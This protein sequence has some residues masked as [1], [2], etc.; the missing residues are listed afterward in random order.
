MR[1]FT[2]GEITRAKA[3]RNAY[4]LRVEIMDVDGAWVNLSALLGTDWVVS[5]EW[6]GALDQPAVSGR[7]EI[8]REG[9]PAA[10]T[11]PLMGASLVNRDALDEYAPLLRGNARI[12]WYTS[13]TLPGE[14]PAWRE[15]FTGYIDNVDFARNPVTL[16]VRDLTARILDAF[17]RSEEIYAASDT[18]VE[19]VIQAIFDNNGLLDVTVVGGV[20]PP[21]LITEYIQQREK[22][23]DAV[24][25]LL[26]PTGH[27][28]R[29]RYTAADAYQFTVLKPIPDSPVSLYTLGGTDYREVQELKIDTASVRNVVQVSWVDEAGVEHITDPITDAASIAKHGERYVLVPAGPAIHTEAEAIAL[30][31]MVLAD[32]KDELST[33]IYEAYYLP[34]TELNDTLTLEANG[35]HYDSDQIVHVYGWAHR[36][37]SDGTAWT[38]LTVGGAPIVTRKGWLRRPYSPP[39]F[40]WPPE[41]LELAFKLVPAGGASESEAVFLHWAVA[42]SWGASPDTKLAH[43]ELRQRGMVWDATEEEYIPD[44]AGEWQQEPNPSRDAIDAIILTPVKDVIEVELTAVNTD[45]ARSVPISEVI[46]VGIFSRYDDLL[47][48]F[49]HAPISET[50]D[51]AS[52]ASRGS[53]VAHVW[54]RH[55]TFHVAAIPA[56]P[57]DALPESPTLQIGE[58]VEFFTLPLPEADHHTFVQVETHREDLTFG[59]SYRYALYPRAVNKQPALAFVEGAGGFNAAN[60]AV[61]VRDDGGETTGRLEVWVNPGSDASVNTTAAPDGYIDITLPTMVQPTDYFITPSGSAVRL[62]ANIPRSRVASKTIAARLRMTDGRSTPIVEHVIPMSLG[63]LL[64]RLGAWQVGAIDDSH[65]LAA[66]LRTFWPFTDMAERDAF[67]AHQLAD[68]DKALVR[69]DYSTWEWD[70]AT[71]TWEPYD[72][73]TSPFLYAPAISAAAIRTLHLHTTT[74]ETIDLRAETAAIGVLNT[75]VLT[76]LQALIGSLSEINEDAGILLHGALVG[77]GGFLDL[78]ATGTETAFEMGGITI[79]ANGQTTTRGIIEAL[80]GVSFM[81]GASAVSAFN[82]TFGIPAG[83]GLEYTGAF[84]HLPQT[85][86]NGDFYVDQDALVF[87]SLNVNGGLSVA[88]GVNFSGLPTSSAGLSSGDLWLNGG[89]VTAA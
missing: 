63:H 64:T 52:W 24:Q 4:A 23:M 53:R 30:G 6:D 26:A 40:V 20:V 39:G 56:R 81:D 37:S 89:V 27:V 58:G 47:R 3:L 11:S 41:N 68:G 44:P 14:A 83:W 19:G 1:S 57:F 78:D 85:S 48:D 13:V 15:A 34:F 9:T 73:E 69:S 71:Q 82:S 7:V 36:F 22:V 8:V 84:I 21:F 60:Y 86:V 42:A 5:A 72:L 75:N 43:Y 66:E 67:P 65:A 17:I 12:R 54:V 74:L 33:H 88:G 29:Y 70:E 31:E 80:G 62:L 49:Q 77:A 16:E 45:G 46:E 18:P 25:A 10:S 55:V 50:V 35:V 32:L 76:A 51:Q 28:A 38:R 2:A 79:L 61:Q 87:G 59:K